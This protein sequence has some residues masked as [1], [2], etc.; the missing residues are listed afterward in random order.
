MND[1][2]KEILNFF[3]SLGGDI[4]TSVSLKET[5]TNNLK[6]LC[7]LLFFFSFFFFFFFNIEHLLK[8]KNKNK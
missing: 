1:I 3:D 6:R 4:D 8:I 5:L 2:F 7:I